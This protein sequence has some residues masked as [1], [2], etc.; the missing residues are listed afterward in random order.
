[1]TLELLHARCM[2]LLACQL[3]LCPVTPALLK[4][5]SEALQVVTAGSRR[6]FPREMLTGLQ[7]LGASTERLGLDAF[8][9]ALKFR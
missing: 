1:M 7:A 6:A 8:S 5:C 9:R 3:Q 2:S 4:A